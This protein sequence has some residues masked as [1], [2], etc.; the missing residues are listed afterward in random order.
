ML[1]YQLANPC[2]IHFFPVSSYT[3]DYLKDDL[4]ESCQ[5]GFAN[6]I[7]YN[8]LNDVSEIDTLAKF[9]LENEILKMNEQMIP[10][11][12]SYTQSGK[13]TEGTDPVIGGRPRSDDSEISDDG[14]ASRDKRD[15]AG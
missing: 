9:S 1:K 10:L 4:L 2:H 14:E 8:T 13:V 5:Y 6:K 12:S 7:A 15:R 3:Y 11:S